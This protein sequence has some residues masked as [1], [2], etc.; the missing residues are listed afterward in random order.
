MF[1][2]SV[3]ALS[4]AG[5]MPPGDGW[6]IAARNERVTVYA[7]ERPESGLREMQAEGLIDAP[8]EE[9]WRALRDYEHHPKTMPY[10]EV[11]R[12]LDRRD[13]DK[14][15]YVYNVLN[16]P[17]VSRR[18][19]V[20]KVVDESAWKDGQ[21][22]LKLTWKTANARAPRGPRD[23]VRIEVN[24]GYWLL[25]PTAGG[26]STRAIYY[27]HT[28]PGG[29]VPKWIVNRVNG[30]AIPDVWEAVRRAAKAR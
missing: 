12:V 30:T 13:G 8:P 3:L 15:L 14:V 25:Q 5:A 4:V 28:D 26:T 2:A 11:A 21:G 22:Y 16:L 7:R 1:I 29:A 23:A 24:D 27:I 6:E 17:M 19:Y 18:D 9:V 10:V 20:L